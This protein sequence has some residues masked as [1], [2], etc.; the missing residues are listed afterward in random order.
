MLRRRLKIAILAVLCVAGS[1]SF[2]NQAGQIPE[3]SG[4]AL[5]FPQIQGWKLSGAIERYKPE[6]LFE[7][8]DGA[9]ELY[10]SYDFKELVVAQFQDASG[11]SSLTAEIYDMGTN[12]SAFGIY[13]AERTPDSHFLPLGTQGYIEEGALNFLDGHYYV[14]LMCYEAVPSPEEW[15]KKFADGIVKKIPG[16]G[17]F[18]VLL[19]VF[20]KDGLIQGSEKFILRN[21]MGF[22]FLKNGYT[23]DY[24]LLG[25]EF[26]CF[27]IEG[28][29]AEDA[30]AMEKQYLDNF[31]RLGIK[32][33]TGA[34]SSHFRD[35]Y[36]RNVYVAQAGRYLCGLTKV[37][38]G[39]EAIG[40]RVLGRM[41]A[42]LKNQASR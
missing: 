8:I 18:P 33:D 30:A 16:K 31:L 29:S 41:L 21:V 23:A 20:P 25:A 17:D 9:A 15:L 42:L 7:Y 11:A 38:D 36:L 26:S 10:L 35:P 34:S 27:L 12:L 4:A 39:Y 2:G 37:K 28:S 14:K 24:N 5:F 22:K 3:M 32:V 6:M 19:A 40:E 13:S 1:F